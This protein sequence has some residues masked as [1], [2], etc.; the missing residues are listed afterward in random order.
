MADT[1][2]DNKKTE[3]EDRGHLSPEK[4]RLRNWLREYNAEPLSEADREY[5]REFGEF[6]ESHPFT[7]R[8]EDPN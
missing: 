4:R 3:A 8:G 6:V 7:F 1:K 5:W 2:T